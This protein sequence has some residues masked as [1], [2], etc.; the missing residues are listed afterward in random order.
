MGRTNRLGMILVA[1]GLIVASVAAGESIVKRGTAVPLQQTIFRIETPQDGDTVFGIVPVKGYVLDQRGV[2]RITLLVD[3]VPVHDADINQPRDDVRRKYSR[4]F[5]EGFPYNPGFSTSFLAS[6]YTAGD[7]TL[8]IRVTYSNSET[9]ELGVRTV[10]VDPTTNQA[11]LGAMD[12]P[13]DE[14]IYGSEGYPI[15][16][17]VTGVYPITGWAIDDQGVRQRLS[18]TGCVLDVDVDCHI[19]ADI[20]IMVDDRVVGQ[21]FYPLPRPDISNAYPDVAGAFRSGFEMNLDTTRFTNGQ[22]TLAV[23]VWDSQGMNRIVDSR[24]IW[25]ENNYTTIGPFGQIN[26]PMPNAHLFATSCQLGGPSGIEFDYLHRLEWISGWVLDQNEQQRFEGVKYVELLLD[27]VVLKRT[28]TDCFY[29]QEFRMDVQCY[30]KNRPDILYQYPQFGADAKYS[31]FFF[32]LD[33]DYLLNTVGIHKGLHYLAIRAGSQDPLRPAV[34]VDQ[35]PVILEC[36]T[37]TEGFPSYGELE[38]PDPYQLL[39]GTQLLRGWV[40]DFDVVVRLNVYVDGVL[41]GSLVHPD[42]HLRMA[43]PDIERRYPWMPAS[44]FL[45]VGFEYNLDTTKYVDGIHQIVL[46]TVDTAG[47]RNY[48]VQRAVSFNNFNRP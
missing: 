2:S 31:G 33:I 25:L 24:T 29:L 5:G 39:K 18:P 32:V 6:N 44:M 48:W 9:A 23:R 13:R 12:S 42:S 16:D 1:V 26:F 8:A 20:E 7:H 21:A 34:I 14:L 35:I 22:H 36:P 11:P 46:E 3:N 43:R 15:Y 10:D 19:L 17:Y 45:N 41:D 30:G 40:W 27:G 4:F 28:S 47:W 38:I 37:N